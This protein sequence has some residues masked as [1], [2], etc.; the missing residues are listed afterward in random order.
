MKFHPAHPLTWDTVDLAIM[1][2]LQRDTPKNKVLPHGQESQDER[3]R[4]KGEGSV[5]WVVL[6]AYYKP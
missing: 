4:S 2:G 5:K 6:G 3:K 1:D